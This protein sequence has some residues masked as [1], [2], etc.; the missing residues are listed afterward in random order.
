MGVEC[1]RFPNAIVPLARRSRSIRNRPTPFAL[2]G[3]RSIATGIATKSRNPWTNKSPTAPCH[4]S[5]ALKGRRS[6]A[7]G[8][9]ATPRNLWKP[10]PENSR[11][12]AGEGSAP[13]TS[14]GNVLHEPPPPRECVQAFSEASRPAGA[15]SDAIS[16]RRR[17]ALSKSSPRPP[18]VPAWRTP[19]HGELPRRPTKRP[20]RQ[21]MQMQMKHRLLRPRPAIKHRAI[22]P[23]PQLLHDALRHQKHSP[24]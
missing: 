2:K 10:D 21:H 12:G 9:A 1:Q 11:S 22:I 15:E 18:C 17:H 8:A 24:H 6:V 20:P 16:R 13:K 19:P 7:T 4:T 3:R 23:M 5:F 14:S